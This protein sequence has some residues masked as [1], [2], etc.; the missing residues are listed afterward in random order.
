MFASILLRFLSIL[1]ISPIY[2]RYIGT[3][4][5]NCLCLSGEIEDDIMAAAS[6]LSVS[7]LS[8]MVWLNFPAADVTPFELVDI[9]FRM[10]RYRLSNC[11]RLC[12]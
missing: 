3:L 10:D 7:T 11:C 12:F 2:G 5:S 6:E 4:I 8:N 1:I 9:V